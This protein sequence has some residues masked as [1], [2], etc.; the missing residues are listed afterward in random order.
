M[1][2]RMTA[3]IKLHTFNLFYPILNIGFLTYSK[4]ACGTSSA[5]RG[6]AIRFFHSFMKTASAVL[7][8]R[9]RANGTDRKYSQ[10]VSSKT[11]YFTTY[12]HVVNFLLKQFANDEV[13]AETISRITCFA[14][15]S[16][17]TPFQYDEELVK[18]PLCWGDVW[19]EWALIKILIED[20]DASTRHSMHEFCSIKKDANQHDLAFHA[21]SL[22]RLQGHDVTSKRTR[23]TELKIQNQRGKPWPSRT[24]GVNVVRS[25]STLKPSTS[26]TNTSGTQVL[27][28]DHTA[29][30]LF[31]VFSDILFL[32]I[33]SLDVL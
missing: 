19:E 13:I 28:L 18:T 29:S 5:H 12:P 6:A 9:P 8:A 22:L 25:E 20:P 7:I 30:Q 2:N 1:A 26:M 33:A 27:A 17:M 3:Q 11:R 4:L 21:T 31:S 32:L 16:S 15:P 14:Q 24:S 10:S 23:P